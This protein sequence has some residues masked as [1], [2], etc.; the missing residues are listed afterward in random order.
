MDYCFLVKIEDIFGFLKHDNLLEV[1]KDVDESN[2]I[3]C[4][5][6]SKLN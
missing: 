1:R 5:I 3:G 6:S 4:S 2:R